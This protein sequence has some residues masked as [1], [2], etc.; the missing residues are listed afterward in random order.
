VKYYD[1]IS[2]NS[3]TGSGM[4]IADNGFGTV[5]MISDQKEDIGNCHL[6]DGNA[7][8]Q[9]TDYIEYTGITDVNECKQNC[10]HDCYSF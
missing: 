7:G 9:D 3:V 5:T 4:Y 2:W 10:L 6:S 1:G 8:I